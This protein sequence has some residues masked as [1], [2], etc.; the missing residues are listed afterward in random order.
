MLD[1][2]NKVFLY[3]LLFSNTSI[4]LRWYRPLVSPKMLWMTLSV[5]LIAILTDSS[6]NAPPPP[7][8]SV[9]SPAG[10]E[11][12]SHFRHPATDRYLPVGGFFLVWHHHYQLF[13]CSFSAAAFWSFLST[14]ALDP[15]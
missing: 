1:V 15:G 13:A 9:H 2:C 7:L 8:S 4:R 6:S 12:R 14:L 3:F 10:G 11:K 5:N